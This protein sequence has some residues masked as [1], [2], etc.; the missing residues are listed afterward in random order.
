MLD[1]LHTWKLTIGGTDRT[2]LVRP[3]S[4]SWTTREGRELDSLSVVLDDMAGVFGSSIA[5]YAPV[6]LTV[7]PGEA[8]EEV[9]FG[10]YVTAPKP[11]ADPTGQ[12]LSWE[13]QASGWEVLWDATP[14]VYRTWLNTAAAKIFTE[15][16]TAAGLD[17]EFD[18]A[19]YVETGP[20]VEVFTAAG[21]KATQLCDALAKVARM[22]WW[23]DPAKNAHLAAE[24]SASQATPFDVIQPGT[25]ANHGLGL[26]EIEAGTLR[27]RPDATGIVNRLRIVGGWALDAPVEDEFAGSEAAT[28][29]IGLA[30]K[31]SHQNI[32]SNVTVSVNGVF[33]V[34]G[35]AFV[36]Y[37]GKVRSDGSV[38]QALVS[39]I[40][41][42]VYFPPLTDFDPDDEIVVGYQVASRR[43]LT[44][45][46]SNS[47][48]SAASLA[49]FGRYFDG[50]LD[51]APVTDEAAMLA[52]GE[53]YLAQ[54]AFAVV[55]GEF[56]T[57]RLGLKAGQNCGITSARDGLSGRYVLR[58]VG[59]ELLATGHVR[60]TAR[61][62]G[63]AESLSSWIGSGGEAGGWVLV[64]GGQDGPIQGDA[65]PLNMIDV[66]LAL[67][68]GTAWDPSDGGTATGLVLMPATPNAAGR[69]LG[70]RDGVVQA[71]F[72]SDGTV[73]A[74]EGDIVLNQ[75]GIL[76][77]KIAGAYSGKA[78][79]W[80]TDPTMNPLGQTKE[81]AIGT[82]VNLGVVIGAQI[83]ADKA[84][85][86][87]S[88]NDVLQIAAYTDIYITPGSGSNVNL[89]NSPRI[90][91]LGNAAADTDALNRQTGDA[92]Y[93]PIA[94]A[95][96]AVTLAADA[97]ALLSLSTQEIGLDAQKANRVLAGP[98]SGVDADPT[99]RALVSA[100]LPA[101][102]AA[103]QGAV[104]LATEAE[105]ATGTDTERGVTPAGLPLRK[106]GDGWA[107]G[108]G[109]DARGV[110]AVDLQVK[111]SA[112]SQVAS[113]L[114]TT[115]GGGANNTAS[116]DGA[117]VG[118]G[119]E[120]AASG[121]GTTVGG[122]YYNTAS[123]DGA[124]VGGGYSNV[125]SG[126]YPTVGGGIG[127]VASNEGA[128]VG[129]GANNTAGDDYATVGGGANN[130]A[131]GD[132]AT[133]GGGLDAVARLYGQ[134]AAAAGGFAAAGDAQRADYV[135]RTVTT[136]AT[137]TELFLD[138]SSARLT[139][140]DNTTLYFEVRVA[141]RRTDVHGESA[142]Y[143][144]RG[145]IDRN[146]GTVALVGSVAKTVVAE[147]SA[148]WD[149]DVTADDTNKALRI[150]VTGE[151]GKTIRWV[152]HVETVEV[153][154]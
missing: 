104:E 131:S 117:T 48:T 2:A 102:T 59:N 12:W 50:D 94:G 40:N 115:V 28:V 100:D 3:G 8:G 33:Q 49:Q 142:A 136:N 95:H 128:T 42:V 68:P 6:V 25:L 99:F 123:N 36:D 126:S 101:A 10:G 46:A 119:I 11:E 5:A 133:V 9:V 18:V 83:A 139:L 41:G 120:N 66:L 17:T 26:Y 24:D 127:N 16:L 146:D 152:A 77:N 132:F 15:L 73:R 39:R 51:V 13:V 65:G 121:W 103:A 111:H 147:D 32:R 38:V 124:T 23:C 43:A 69:L 154:G 90:T 60:S 130:T 129:G 1:S 86:L 137:S 30:F 81:L 63:R 21:E 98:A 122:G 67:K 150:T 109:G 85:A 62:G 29:S 57:Q 34:L 31:L 71:G 116:N 89:A 84:L 134:H 114:Y 53:A 143:H 72:D 106:I 55:S 110:G 75:Y 107:L 135:L 35:T 45:D 70:Y 96:A 27:V 58:S 82:D 79:L 113:G 87:V 118:G 138:G 80:V 64:G 105:A 145:C 54:Y 88:N 44:L 112:A 141:A 74:A 108:T 144:F 92:R 148:A 4:L 47:A 91:G 93:A 20:T 97:D 56:A 78:L 149:V 140:I 19:T 153:S 7:D 14:R 151:A 61:F 76:L 125:A 22:A 37:F 52:L